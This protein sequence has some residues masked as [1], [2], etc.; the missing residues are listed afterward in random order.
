MGVPRGRVCTAQAQCGHSV[1]RT[2]RNWGF[3]LQLA[4]FLPIQTILHP[5]NVG[6]PDV[7]PH[8]QHKRCQC[9]QPQQRHMKK[10]KA[11]IK[12]VLNSKCERHTPLR[13]AYIQDM[14]HLTW[15]PH[16][17]PPFGYVQPH[18]DTSC[19]VMGVL[20]CQLMRRKIRTICTYSR[21]TGYV[22][23]KSG[24]RY[25]KPIGKDAQQHIP[26]H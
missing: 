18:G 23:G 3:L 14:H 16:P 9:T 26:M 2:G 4:I 19:F 25:H 5:H 24:K 7:S 15:C 10:K 20:C 22:L 12:F 6:Q 1:H 17:Q 8:P 13:L 11:R 21:A